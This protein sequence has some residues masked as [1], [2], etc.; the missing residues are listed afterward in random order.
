[1]AYF[2]SLVVLWA[3]WRRSDIDLRKAFYIGLGLGVLGA[4]GTFQTFFQ[5]FAP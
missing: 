5:A 3:V 1:L 4:I 2:L